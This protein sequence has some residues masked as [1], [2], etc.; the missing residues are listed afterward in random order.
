MPVRPARGF[1]VGDER[2]RA[3]D[4]PRVLGE[5]ENRAYR[6]EPLA[7]AIAFK[8]DLADGLMAC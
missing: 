1:R 2:G 3:R 5:I 6:V 4:Q 8:V 7:A